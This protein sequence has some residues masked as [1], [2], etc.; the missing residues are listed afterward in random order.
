MM[1]SVISILAVVFVF[2]FSSC[3]KEYLCRCDTAAGTGNDGALFGVKGS[4]RKATKECEK[5]ANEDPVVQPKGN[6]LL[7]ED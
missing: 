3:S 7:L 1:K 5:I 4:K 6:C 2:A